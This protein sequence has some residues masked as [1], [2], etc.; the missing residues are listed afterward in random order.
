MTAPPQVT[1]QPPPQRRHPGRALT[2]RSHRLLV[3]VHV[4]TTVGLLGADLALLA[5][6]SAGAGGAAPQEIYP[7]MSLL[8][9]WLVAPLAL[10][11]LASGLLL[12][13]LS[14]WG[15]LRYWWVAVKLATTVGLTVALLVVLVPGLNAAANAATTELPIPQR[16]LYA[17]APAAASILLTVNAAL[18]KYKPGRTL[19][20][21]R[22]ER[23]R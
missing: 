8:A 23:N 9:Q 17:I 3:T 15:L 2:P 1:R 12:G 19:R 22:F 11:A 7:A 6:G 16:L 5:L 13:A 21:R 14:S 20:T 4:L 18:G 10:A